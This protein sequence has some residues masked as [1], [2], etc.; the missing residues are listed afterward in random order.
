MSRVLNRAG[1]PPA[2]ALRGAGSWIELASGA[3]VLDGA[4][5]AAVA[6]IGHGNARVAGAIAGQAAALSYL[7]SAFFTSS[8]AE[9]LAELLVESGGGAFARAFFVS[10]GSESVEAALKL[11][12]QYH[13]ERGEPARTHVIARRQSYH[14]NTLGALSAS[15]HAARRA[16]YEPML[17]PGFSHVSPCQAFRHRPPGLSDADWVAALAAELEAEITRLGPGRVAAFLAETVVGATSGCTPAVPGY[18][19]AMRAVCDRHGVLLVLDEIMCGMGRT[20][21]RHAWED[22]GI[23][24][25]IQTVAKGLGGGYVPIGAMLVGHRVV[26]ALEAGSGA[27]VHGHTYQAH[28]LAARGALEVQRIIAEEGLVARVARLAP[29]LRARAG[30]HLGA[31]PNIADIRGRGFFLGLECVADRESGAPFPAAAG[32]S[33]RVKDAALRRGLAIYPGSGTIDGLRGDHIIL[34]P[35]FNATEDELD[36]LVERLAGAVEDARLSLSH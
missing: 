25:D 15:G 8:P 28:P 26:A 21:R 32:F 4:G 22:E 35:P 5:G 10:S 24:P 13:V 1:P 27:F 7:H 6:C 3:R 17:M 12:R 19:P 36:L 18:F 31:H 30:Q 33:A 34:A 2:L 14:G 9:E 23:T 11:A 29:G 16:I 20:G